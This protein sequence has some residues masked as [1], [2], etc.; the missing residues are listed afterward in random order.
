M[1]FLHNL[2]VTMDE[3]LHISEKI[4]DDHDADQ[5]SI[6]IDENPCVIQGKNHRFSQP[7]D[8]FEDT[9][10]YNSAIESLDVSYQNLI[11]FRP[12]KQEIFSRI[13]TLYLDHNELSVLP[14]PNQIPSLKYLSCGW[15]NLVVVPFYPNL[16]FLDVSNNNIKSLSNYSKIAKKLKSLDCSFNN[17]IVVPKFLHSCKNLYISNCSIPIFDISGYPSLRVLDCSHNRLKRIDGESDIMKEVNMD[18]NLMVSMPRWQSLEYIS[19]KNNKLTR[20]DVY[21]NAHTIIVDNNSIKRISKQPMLKKLVASYNEIEQINSCP[22]A[23]LLKLEHNK[24]TKLIVPDQLKFLDIQYN[25]ISEIDIDNSKNSIRCISSDIEV[26]KHIYK[27]YHQ[28]IDSIHISC[29][30]KR[31]ARIIGQF[32]KFISDKIIQAIENL[33]SV[34]H[35]DAYIHIARIAAKIH[36]KTIKTNGKTAAEITKLDTFKNIYRKIYKVYIN[37]VIVSVYFNGYRD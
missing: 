15:N 26:Y 20:I 18:N 35:T 11:K 17:N 6:F 12:P 24:L 32:G 37:C 1:N 4:I 2:N 31:M 13:K 16:T 34:E 3:I 25:S 30:S 14:L 28:M 5:D 27:K 33:G 10:N 23:T 22:R 7:S 36:E 29:D 19:A 21:P 8:K 9:S